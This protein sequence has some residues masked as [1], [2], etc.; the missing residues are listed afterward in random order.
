[1]EA[2]PTSQPRSSFSG[3][4]FHSLSF[5]ATHQVIVRVF[6]IPHIFPQVA[7]LFPLPQVTPLV[8]LTSFS[9][10]VLRPCDFVLM[11]GLHWNPYPSCQSFSSTSNSTRLNGFSQFSSPHI[12]NGPDK[13]KTAFCAVILAGAA[14]VSYITLPRPI[15]HSPLVPTSAANIDAWFIIHYLS[16]DT[17]FL[18]LT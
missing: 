5:Y 4:L 8:S 6:R 14:S 11:V 7:P 13:G 2:I 3:S 9:V 15:F 1:M 17:Y 16:A 12:N 18:P 10:L